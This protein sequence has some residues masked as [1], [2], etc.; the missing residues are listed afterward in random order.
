MEHLE[1]QEQSGVGNSEFPS[2]FQTH[3]RNLE[4]SQHV[5]EELHMM[6]VYSKPQVLHIE[7]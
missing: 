3:R 7:I 1:C 2:A 6:E 4:T 5:S